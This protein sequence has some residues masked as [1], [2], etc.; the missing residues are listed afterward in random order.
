MSAQRTEA[1]GEFQDF[2]QTGKHRI[3][4]PGQ[5][6]WLSM[7]MCVSRIL[8]QCESLKLYFTGVV[9]EDPAHTNDA[10]LKS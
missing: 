4:R 1:F 3:L 8:E 2:L 9:F 6:R 10:I 7:K 5:T